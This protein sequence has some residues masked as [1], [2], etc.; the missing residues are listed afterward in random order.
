MNLSRLMVLGL[1]ASHGPLHGHRIRRDAEQTNVGNWGGVSVGAL[2][3]ELREMEGEGLVEPVRTE[4]E[5]RRPARTVY[6]IT[7]EG[8]RELRILRERAICDLRFGPDAFGVALVFGR[9][10]DRAELIV[11]LRARRQAI[12]SALEG[13]AAACA[14]LQARGAI[15]PLDAAMF[16]RR[17]MQLEAELRWHEEFER[18]LPTLPEPPG[19]A[20]GRR[21]PLRRP[22]ASLHEAARMRR[23]GPPPIPGSRDR[24]E[25][26][27]SGRGHHQEGGPEWA[28]SPVHRP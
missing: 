2:Y 3:R 19:P 5:G 10:W 25:R 4:R 17:G 8:R 18:V 9:T 16:R 1:L 21:Q 6:R 12:A 24:L 23:R 28:R 26:P 20:A 15:G 27:G 11:P 22:S 14:H 13:I 7:V